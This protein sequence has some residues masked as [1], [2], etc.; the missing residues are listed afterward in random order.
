MTQDRICVVVLGARSGTSATT[1][2]L[3]LLGCT[4]PIN[5]MPGNSANEK[6]YFEPSEIVDLNDEILEQLNSRWDD[7]SALAPAWFRSPAADIYAHRLREKVASNYGDGCLIALKDPRI[8]RMVPYWKLILEGVGIHPKFLMVNRSPFLVAKSLAKRDGSTIQQ[9]LMYWLRNTLEAERDT[10]GSERVFISYDSLISD[11]RRTMARVE[12]RL[13]IFLDYGNSEMVDQ[14][15]EDRLRHH[16]DEG[17]RSKERDF[18]E[19]LAIDVNS[20]IQTLI[21]DDSDPKAMALL[22]EYLRSFDS[23]INNSASAR[24]PA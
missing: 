13:N 9:G 1:G 6:G 19:T 20:A 22:D 18:I 12:R 8:S 15:L 16:N 4:L 14:F 23:F 21:E 10:R 11:W 7:F 17:P 24:V 5:L 2:T 3:G